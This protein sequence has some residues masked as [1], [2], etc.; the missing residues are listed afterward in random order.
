MKHEQCGIANRVR[1]G[2]FEADFK[3][4]ELTK[5]GNRVRIQGQPLRVLDVLLERPGQVISREE[6]QERLW[7]SDTNVDFDHSLGIAVNKLREALDDS[8]D[9]PRY[10]ET[11]ARRGYRFI[12]PVSV[13]GSTNESPS[14][15][16]S[17][18]AKPF[19]SVDRFKRFAPYVA[20]TFGM[21]TVILVALA[22]EI[23][24]H[25]REP[26]HN[27]FR[28]IRVTQSG[29]VLASESSIETFA[30]TA[31]DGTRIYF[32]HL[33]N[34]QPVLAQV[35]IANGEISDLSLPLEIAAPQI[36]SL[37]PD[38]SR[39]I[40]C[41]HLAAAP[42]QPLWIVPT[43]GGLAKRIPGVTGHDA[44]WMPDGRHVLY[45]VG[46]D[47]NV[48]MED[49]TENR[50]VVSL[51]GRAFWLRQ[52]P[53]GNHVRFTIL[54]SDSRTSSLWDFEFKRGLLRPVL[55]DWSSP[56]S[57]CCGSWT[58]DGKY[59]V[60]QSRHSGSNDIWAISG[61]GLSRFLKT[62]PWQITSGPL[63]Y[64]APVTSPQGHRIYFVGVDS[65]YELLLQ[66]PESGQFVPLHQNPGAAA[67]I[68]YSR[69]GKW[70]AWLNASDGSLWRSRIDGS[71]RLQL[72]T[73]PFHGFMMKWAPDDKELAVMGQVPRSPWTI[74]L[75]DASGG[76]IQPLLH[77]QGRGEA[78][79]DWSPDSGT[80][81]FG[82]V[83]DR[84]GYEKQPKA[85][86]LVNLKTRAMTEVPD[87]VGLFSPRFSPDGRFIAA[88][89][90]DQKALLVF[91]RGSETWRQLNGSHGA[92][93][94]VWANDSQFL[95]FQDFLENGK[96]IYR[97]D[98]RNDALQQV[99][100]LNA[101]I[102]AQVL[103]YRLTTLAPGNRLVVGAR[104]ASVNL[105]QV[106]LDQH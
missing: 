33:E 63:D 101:L 98:V 59:F 48:V 88:I 80:I 103:D 16:E 24:F 43:L 3:N 83:P 75:V 78:D 39:L 61:A 74:F 21:L 9:A 15:V 85:I 47:L 105:Y 104:N 97:V 58:A 89:R 12:A 90:L 26:D 7:G 36:G 46:N 93:D 2:Q 50:K 8:A 102:P 5:A 44:T 45:A 95:F 92:G 53:G 28:V 29:D 56:S 60:F 31:T 69:D 72:T 65:Q 82:R 20:V 68:E 40:V 4:G 18:I 42:E 32:S 54:E 106:D 64:E 17:A 91:D 10:I 70:I 52:S 84:M 100:T 67:Q 14:V 71:E 86:Y 79:P 23:V 25:F 87:S 1:F 57:E 73:P 6:I 19:S 27:L 30:G 51:N 81:V 55:A 66:T 22:S 34:G 76:G 94:P 13:V 41:N 35:L 38:G 62:H 77:E 49:G 37:S 96:P 99:A 11:L